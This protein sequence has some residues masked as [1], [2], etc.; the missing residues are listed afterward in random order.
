[1]SQSNGGFESV[2]HTM[3][4]HVNATH[5]IFGEAENMAIH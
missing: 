2:M 5:Q 4:V 3:Y 1:M